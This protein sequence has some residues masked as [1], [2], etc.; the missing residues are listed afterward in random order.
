MV[1]QILLV[2]WLFVGAEFS[3]I[4]L[5]AQLQLP[6]LKDLDLGT[7][8]WLTNIVPKTSQVE[9]I[10]TAMLYFCLPA[11]LLKQVVNVAQLCSAC[12]A[13]AAYDAQVHNNQ[14]KKG[15]SI[16][17]NQQLQQQPV[18]EQSEQGIHSQLMCATR[19]WRDEEVKRSRLF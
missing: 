11:C 10:V 6:R 8:V 14:N 5:Y 17:Q 16:E 18:Q 1:F 9:W 12:H 15:A 7:P 13:I 3:Y 19:E 2:L 4:L